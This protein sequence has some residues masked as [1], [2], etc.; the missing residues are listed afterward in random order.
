M[1]LSLLWTLVFIAFAWCLAP[2]SAQAQERD[3]TAAPVFAADQIEQL[4][5]PIALYPDSLV[6]Q[7]LM[8][9]TY[10]L[11]IVQAQR[12]REKH[13]DLEGKDLEDALASEPWDP[14]VKALTNFADVLKRMSDNLDWTQDLG[15]AVLGQEAEVRDLENIKLHRA[16]QD[17]NI[18]ARQDC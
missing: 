18:P 11:E 1:R 8:A 5:A 7:I 17:S 16:T 3:D 14:S 9:S 13:P 12:W 6:A 2:M 15:D 4:V 10:P